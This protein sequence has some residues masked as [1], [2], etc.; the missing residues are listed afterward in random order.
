MRKV[1]KTSLKRKL[2]KEASRIVRARGGCAKCGKVAYEHLQTA[3][4]FSRSNLAV[5]WDLLNLLCLCDGCHFWAHKNPVLFTE[6]VVDYLGHNYVPLK[7]RALAI[8]KWTIEEMQEL[9]NQLQ[10]V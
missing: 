8:R 6:F 4:I 10:A 1:T 7:Q 2:D 5:R 3:H 9:L